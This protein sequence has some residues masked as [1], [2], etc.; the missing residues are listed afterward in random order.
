M[1]FDV[2]DR[3]W[4]A[5]R[6]VPLLAVA[7]F[8]FA[9]HAARADVQFIVSQP[10][11]GV[12]DLVDATSGAVST[13]A[14]LPDGASPQVGV[15]QD[16]SGNVYSLDASGVIYQVSPTGTVSTFATMSP[17]LTGSGDVFRGLT[18][19]SQGNLYA[20]AADESSYKT[21]IQKITPNGTQSSYATL[22]YDTT[23]GIGFNKS[24][25]TLYTTSGYHAGQVYAIDS[26]GNTT[27][28]FQPVDYGHAFVDGD[29]NY[30]Y[31]DVTQDVATDASGNVFVTVSG[32]SYGD[33]YIEEI[34]ASGSAFTLASLP[35]GNPWGI[36]IGSD[37][38]VYVVDAQSS[39]ID[40]VASDGTVTAVATTPG[41]P[42]GITAYTAKS[43]PEPASLALFPLGLGLLASVRRRVRASR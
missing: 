34:P 9:T 23:W 15:V 16:S 25:N 38:Q 24:T 41:Q 39:Q 10:G 30:F 35:G 42:L 8:S 40:L 13:F 4:A 14:T 37:G 20:S 6:L 7:A 22:P 19:D 12:L 3:H 36:T 11:N 43:V 2:A 26:L 33:N 1:G 18:I 31:T 17:T 27:L 28:V 29:G 5:R 32:T 21:Q